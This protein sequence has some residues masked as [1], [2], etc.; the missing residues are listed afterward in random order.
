M[1]TF[2]STVS[3][4]FSDEGN[5]K[6]TKKSTNTV[7]SVYLFFL[8]HFS[9]VSCLLPDDLQFSTTAIYFIFFFFF[10]F[11][12]DCLRLHL[13]C[14]SWWSLIKKEEKKSKKC[15]LHLKSLKGIKHEVILGKK[16]VIK[17]KWHFPLACFSLSRQFAFET[18]MPFVRSCCLCFLPVRFM[19]TC[20]WLHDLG[21]FHTGLHSGSSLAAECRCSRKVIRPRSC[22]RDHTDTPPR[23]SICSPRSAKTRCRPGTYRDLLGQL[24]PAEQ[25]DRRWEQ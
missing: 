23:W 22:I 2:F 7:F 9:S 1:K 8:S 14:K 11:L 3:C 12:R 13:H 4:T 21:L 15:G 18:V 17:S 16:K 19:R 5:D 25:R 20:R 6:I 10:S 24:K